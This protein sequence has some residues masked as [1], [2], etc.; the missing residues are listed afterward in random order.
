MG[1]KYNQHIIL[2]KKKIISWKQEDDKSKEKSTKD[3]ILNPVE[4]DWKMLKESEKTALSEAEWHP[5]LKKFYTKIKVM[6][7][8][9][10]N[11]YFTLAGTK[12][13]FIESYGKT[14][15]S[16]DNKLY[17]VTITGNERRDSYELK[18]NKKGKNNR[19]L[20]SI[21]VFPLPN[22]TTKEIYNYT[23]GEGEEL[24]LKLIGLLERYF[25]KKK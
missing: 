17:T 13:D 19:L 20:Q 21:D 1:I 22:H 2:K 10:A 8:K 5:L 9:D 6:N 23:G 4:L 15:L 25:N 12:W 3:V 7:A 14:F 24:T 18:I 16:D 11:K